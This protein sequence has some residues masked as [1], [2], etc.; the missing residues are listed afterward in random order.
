M[1][2]HNTELG[3]GVG[4]AMEKRKSR[5]DRLLGFYLEVLVL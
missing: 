1:K 4:G 3:M 5:G 2:E